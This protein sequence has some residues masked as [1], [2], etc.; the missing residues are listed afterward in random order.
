[1]SAHKF[2]IETGRIENKNQTDRKCPLCCVGIG[3]ELHYLIE[4]KNK[5]ITKTRSE[6]L[7]P[8][9]NRWKSIQKLTQVEFC[10]AILTSQNDD[11]IT[12]TGF[13]VKKSKK[14]IKMKLY[15]A[16]KAIFTSH[17]NDLTSRTTIYCN[18]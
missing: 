4:C 10:K 7:K 11:M 16:H 3:N 2:L 18:H 14:H 17:L 1:M 9:Y 6:Y 12:E 13:Y 15:N 5:A 8:F